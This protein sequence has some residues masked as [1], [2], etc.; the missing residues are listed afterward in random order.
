[1]NVSTHTTGS[2]SEPV[3][4]SKDQT[5]PE[6]G[7]RNS[8]PRQTRIT[9]E[10]ET[11]LFEKLYRGITSPIRLLPDFLIIGTQRGGTTSLYNYLQWHP[12]IGPS[13]TKEIH[14]FDRQ[15]HKGL[16]WYRGHFPTRAER[17][18]TQSFRK[19]AF[20]TGEAS[21]AY[22]FYPHTAERVAETLPQARLIALLRNPVDRA[23]S[24]YFH[25]VEHG[26]ET[27]SFE[28]AIEDE[29]ER[30]A[31]ERDKIVQDEHFKSYDYRH[32]SYLSRG[33][34]VEQLSTW[35]G[36]FPR[37]QFLILKSEDFY[38]DPLSSVKQVLA[39]LGLPLEETLLKKQEFK[40]Y[41]NN[42][43]TRMDTA[44]RGR[45]VEYFEPHNARLYDFLGVDFGWDR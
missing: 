18:Y 25:A 45:L 16:R 27:Q 28:E 33:I 2:K 15:M 26:F 24:Q 30:T 3:R 29:I 19:R 23:Y 17:Y 39:F 12:S 41:N 22:L 1:M 6:Q 11:P 34:Y 9:R 7:Q 13:S 14:F 32:R 36:L 44:L 20:V 5:S 4:P 42:P 21:P 43:Y 8:A 37:E 35:M 40:Q 31:A 10:G 38:A